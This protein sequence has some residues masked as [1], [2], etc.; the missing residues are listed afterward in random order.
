MLAEGGAEGC[1]V[2]EAAGIGGLCDGIPLSLQK[3][4]CTAD[5]VG[6]QILLWGN[7]GGLHENLVQVGAVNPY[8]SGDVL[9]FHVVRIIVPDVL[10]RGAVILFFPGKAGR[11]RNGRHAGENQEK[12]GRQ[13]QHIPTKTL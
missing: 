3:G 6:E 11:S 2:P 9:D 10:H 12:P 7:T 1:R 13:L 8:K 5:S 4:G